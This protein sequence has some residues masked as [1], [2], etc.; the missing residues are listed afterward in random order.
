MF[1][2]RFAP[3]L[4]RAC[5]IPSLRLT[6]IPKLQFSLIN[7]YLFPYPERP[8]PFSLELQFCHQIL[9]SKT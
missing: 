8:L 9:W 2:V 5:N 7:K 6:T 3:L 4:A 1:G